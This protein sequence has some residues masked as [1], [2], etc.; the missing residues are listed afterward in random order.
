VAAEAEEERET[1]VDNADF[2]RGEVP[3]DAPDAALI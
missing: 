1:L 2:V 3:E